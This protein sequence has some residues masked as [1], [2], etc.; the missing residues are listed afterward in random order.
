[1]VYVCVCVRVRVYV[2]CVQVHEGDVLAS[3]DD[4]DMGDKTIEYVGSKIA[5][6][7][8]LS[9]STRLAP[10]NRRGS[11]TPLPTYPKPA[12]LHSEYA[13]QAAES[14]QTL[15]T[16]NTGAAGSIVTLGLKN[17]NNLT[18]PARQVPI[19]RAAAGPDRVRHDE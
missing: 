11:Q 9:F 13:A 14:N 8:L 4:E 16:A 17:P 6:K 12:S 15:L 7:T 10:A 2:C 19:E 18:S 5:G 3:V 1:M